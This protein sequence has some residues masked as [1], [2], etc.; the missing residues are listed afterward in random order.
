MQKLKKPDLFFQKWQEVGEFW[1][2][3][4][5]LQNLHFDWFFLCNVYNVCHKKV[6]RSY[7]NTE[8]WCKIWRKTDFWFGKWQE[9]C[10]FLLEHLKVSKLGLWWDRFIQS[11]K[12]MSLKF[13]EDSCVKTM[14]NDASFREALTFCF[15]NF[16]FNDLFLTKVYN[17][18]AKKAQKR[19]VW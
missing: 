2:E 15:K 3:H 17:T 18:W 8:E 19:N 5:I 6:Q 16:R 9:F 10:R 7:L 11:R 1:P 12:C 14:K 13:P 4:S